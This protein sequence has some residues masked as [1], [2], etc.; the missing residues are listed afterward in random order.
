[1]RKPAKKKPLLMLPGDEDPMHR[2]WLR[3]MRALRRMKAGEELTDQERKLI[4]QSQPGMV[5]VDPRH[6]MD[7]LKCAEFHD[8][9]AGDSG[10]LLIGPPMEVLE[11]RLQEAEEK[12]R[13]KDK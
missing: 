2:D 13:R 10:D 1:M 6:L 4:G 11:K 7:P 12:R 5:T 8:V 9:L 3:I